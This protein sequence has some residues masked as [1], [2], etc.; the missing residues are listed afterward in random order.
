WKNAASTRISSSPRAATSRRCPAGTTSMRS[1]TQLTSFTHAADIRIKANGFGFPKAVCLFFARIVRAALLAVFAGRDAG[2][3]FED[4]REVALVVE[5]DSAGD[6]RDRHP[7][8][9]EQSLAALNAQAVDVLGE[10]AAELVL[11]DAAE[12]GF[13]QVDLLGRLIERQ[14]VGQVLL[15]ES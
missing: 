4:A 9:A 15:D 2:L 8:G 3:L 5:P 6:L 12:V 11:D 1:L 10:G 13:G 14:L 7:G